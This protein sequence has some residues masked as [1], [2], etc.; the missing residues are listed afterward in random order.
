MRGYKGS[1]GQRNSR[2]GDTIA[3]SE[4]KTLFADRFT[5]F[6]AEQNFEGKCSLLLDLFKLQIA[7]A[8]MLYE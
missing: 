8:G 4:L 3:L 1:F 7:F 6:I 2:I 5:E